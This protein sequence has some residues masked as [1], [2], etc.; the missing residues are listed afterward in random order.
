[1]S[2]TRWIEVDGAVLAAE[3]VVNTSADGAPLVFLHAGVTDRRMWLAQWD[4]F[5]TRHTMLRYDRRGFGETR[6]VKPCSYSRVA[7]LCA[8]TDSVELEKAVLVGCSQG[9]RIALDTAL[10]QPER[11]SALVLVASAVSGAPQPELTGDVKRLRDAI[12]AAEDA[13]DVNGTNEL[14]AQLWL[15]GPSSAPGRVSGAARRLFLAMNDIALR[16]PDPGEAIEDAPAWERL[17]HVRVP[18]LVLWGDLDLPHLQA[19]CEEVVRRIPAA[20]R[21]VLDGTAHLPS[22]EAPE[23]FDAVLAEFL[24]SA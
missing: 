17:E 22:M 3:F 12:N 15:D 4:A 18:T 23:R 1:M 16:A 20:K 10:T 19:R 8:V 11:V 2:T 14:E 6:L 7:D 21:V 13:G 5:S 24:A 9:G